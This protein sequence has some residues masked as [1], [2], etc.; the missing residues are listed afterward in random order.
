MDARILRAIDL[1]E[2]RMDRNLSMEA[3]AAEVGLSLFHF[4]R[5][6]LRSVG[7]TPA[8]YLRRIRLD[9]AALRLRWTRQPVGEIAQALG[10]CSQAAFTRA[11]GER[12][13]MS[14]LRFRKDSLMWP[15]LPV[16]GRLQHA[17]SERILPSYCCVARR[18]FG[19]LKFVPQCWRRFV[20]E[21]PEFVRPIAPGPYIGLM[22][23][24]PRFTPPEQIRYDCCV[25][26]DEEGLAEDPARL[27]RHELRELRIRP[28]RYVCQPH[29]GGY[30][31]VGKSYSRLLDHWI[32][33]S[34][35]SLTEDPAIEWYEARPPRDASGALDILLMLPVS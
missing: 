8:E 20:H 1:M 16:D 5:L 6:F 22:Y 2:S 4:H 31:D 15:P 19:S 28:G 32:A 17:A 25:V 30:I 26:V 27:A 13:G 14:P 10:Y 3:L 9:G 7:E 34:S 21:L 23:D 29:H 33:T 35:Y 24:D 12:F 11:F 18:F